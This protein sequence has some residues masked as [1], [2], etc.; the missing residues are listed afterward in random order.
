MLHETGIFIYI[1]HKVK[2]NVGKDSVHGEFGIYTL[3][4][5]QVEFRNDGN[6]P[7]FL[8]KGC[9]TPSR[10][11]QHIPLKGNIK[12]IDSKVRAARGHMDA[13]YG[14]SLQ[15]YRF[16]GFKHRVYWDSR[17]TF[18]FIF[19]SHAVVRIVDETVRSASWRIEGWCV[20]SCFRCFL[21]SFCIFEI[22][23]C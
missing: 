16:T 19:P 6:L 21:W 15:K 4:G 5:T 18:L 17:Y 23:F 14:S 1:Y 2:P 12:I 11:V 22:V 20:L 7:R 3:Q 10:L 8:F 9:N 13:K